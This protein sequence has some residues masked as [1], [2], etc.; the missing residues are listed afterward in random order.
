MQLF[1]RYPK[2]LLNF[3]DIGTDRTH[4]LPLRRQLFHKFCPYIPSCAT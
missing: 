2:L 1:C 4:R 3:R